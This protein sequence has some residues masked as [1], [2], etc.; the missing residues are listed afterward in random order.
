MRPKPDESILKGI[1]TEKVDR[2]KA[3]VEKKTKAQQ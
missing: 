2:Q 1:K 3:R